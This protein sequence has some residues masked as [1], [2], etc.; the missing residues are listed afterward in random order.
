M[1][2]SLRVSSIILSWPDSCAC[3]GQAPETHLRANPS[4]TP[5]QGVT[6]PTT[7]WWEIP[8]CSR[9]SRHVA[10]H[11]LSKREA[12][13]GIGGGGLVLLIL[14]MNQDFRAAT[15]LLGAV[16]AVLLLALLG[17]RLLKGSARKMMGPTCAAPDLALEYRGWDGASHELVFTS[18]PYLG[19]FMAVNE[20]KRITTVRV[21]ERFQEASW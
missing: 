1:R 12:Q 20:T 14:I 7:T 5:S 15:L 13:A 21:I 11:R 18:K 17:S 8:Y 10:M 16:A 3:C 19:A 9:C 4:E 2:H 6:R